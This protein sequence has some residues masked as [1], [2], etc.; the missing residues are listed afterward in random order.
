MGRPVKK[1]NFGNTATSGSQVQVT[2][3]L[4]GSAKA[5]Y[6]VKQVGTNSYIVTDGT[7]T[8]RV[9]LQ[10]TAPTADGQARC[11]VKNFGG[12]TST[13]TITIA[14]PGV[15]SWVGHGK[16]AGDIVVFST[17]GAL[18]TNITAGTTYYVISAGLDADSFRIS[19]TPGGSAINT[20]GSQSGTH[21]VTSTTNDY[22]RV[23]QAKRVKTFGGKTYKWVTTDSTDP[24]EAKVQNA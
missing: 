10:S 20:T 1:V 2:A 9:K 12:S 21:T 7:D 13:V 6:V 14:T 8:A 15:V 4:G 24:T 23:L 11:L 3:Y 5:A 19:S 17:T 22:A 18:P 16:V